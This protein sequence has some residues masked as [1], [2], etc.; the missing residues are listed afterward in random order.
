MIIIQ[1][2]YYL[3]RRKYIYDCSRVNVHIEGINLVF[4]KHILRYFKFTGFV[5]VVLVGLLLRNMVY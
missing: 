2:I 1:E 5:L 4:Q 3:I